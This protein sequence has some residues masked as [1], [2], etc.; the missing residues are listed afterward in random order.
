MFGR[1][2]PSIELAVDQFLAAVVVRNPDAKVLNIEGG[3]IELTLPFRKTWLFHLLTPWKR[4]FLRRF[5]FD[6]TGSEL[7]RLFDDKWTVQGLA[8][9]LQ[10]SQ[11]LSTEQAQDSTIAFVH[12]LLVRGLVGLVTRP[13]S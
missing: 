12:M 11:N 3:G 2:S 5:E 10:R 6:A 1:K 9:H 7:W 13:R 8:D 4:T